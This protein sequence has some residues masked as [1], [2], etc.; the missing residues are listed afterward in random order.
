MNPNQYQHLGFRI[1]SPHDLES[2]LKKVRG[3]MVEQ[4]THHGGTYRVYTN[5]HG[6]QLYAQYDPQDNLIGCLT[7]LVADCRYR[8]KFSGAITD[9]RFP[10]DG[11]IMSELVDDQPG[12]PFAIDSPNFWV[13]AHKLEPESE[14]ELQ[15][16]GFP[17]Q[18]A[19]YKSVKEF[20]KSPLGQL[21]HTGAMI[22]SGL[23]SPSG[24]A[25][26][27]PTGNAIICGPIEQVELCK[28]GFMEPGFWKCIVSTLGGRVVVPFSTSGLKSKP[29]VGGI[30][31]GSVSVSGLIL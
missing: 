9:Q 5:K 7:H 24:E 25:V 6:G 1:Q 15:I 29:K 2:F 22:P 20:S 31:A 27:R 12:V 13:D 16:T 10:M 19:F 4:N 8:V 3:V 14:V 28:S 30:I 17:Q 23:F 11:L 26:E 21:A 18:A